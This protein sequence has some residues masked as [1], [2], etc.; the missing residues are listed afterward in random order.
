MDMS[1]P[2]DKILFLKS[3]FNSESEL[4]QKIQRQF[5]LFT[6][7]PAAQGFVAFKNISEFNQNRLIEFI[8]RKGVKAILDTRSVNVF[9]PPRFD[10]KVLADYFSQRS[11]WYC[12]FSSTTQRMKNIGFRN[13]FIVSKVLED[14][15][16]E[17]LKDGMILVLYDDEAKK[18][19]FVSD[20]RSY[21]LKFPDT[22]IDL[23]NRF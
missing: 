8:A 12:N 2:N 1:N 16:I 6:D 3:H 14:A 10:H 13:I 23:S 21:L 20:I 15:I 19:G 17:K 7:H 9:D 4:K 22:K 5:A 11:I 18:D